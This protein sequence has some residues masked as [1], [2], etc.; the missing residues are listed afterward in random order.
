MWYIGR[1]YCTPLIHFYP[2]L[3]PT[4]GYGSHIIA[5][6]TTYVLQHKSGNRKSREQE[7]GRGTGTQKWEQKMGMGNRNG[8]VK[9]IVGLDY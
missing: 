8:T 9:I 2:A 5:V 6:L 7:T 3:T 4:T 1:I